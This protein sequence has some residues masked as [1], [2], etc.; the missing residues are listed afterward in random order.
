M[1]KLLKSKKGFTLVEL[2][3]VVV[4][5]AILVAVAVP[6]F[7]AVTKN[8]RTK[9]CLANQREIQAQFNN[10]SMSGILKLA[11]GD[12][13]VLTTNADAD[14]GTWA[15]DAAKVAIIEELFQEVPY[16]PVEGN[17][18]TVTVAKANLTGSEA[19][20]FKI[21]TVCGGADETHNAD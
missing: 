13:F 10:N 20:S 21:T 19:E 4:I 6:I 9:T 5:M 15:G 3:I 14:G 12:E 1:F 11:A 7:S 17:T 16:C 18:I 8:A 2:M